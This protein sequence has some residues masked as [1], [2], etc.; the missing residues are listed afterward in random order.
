MVTEVFKTWKFHG[1][2][3]LSPWGHLKAVNASSS[4]LNDR[5]HWNKYFYFPLA[6]CSWHSLK[7]LFDYILITTTL[8]KKY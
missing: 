6:M 5:S 7:H 4:S 1:E 3:N 2:I 8:S